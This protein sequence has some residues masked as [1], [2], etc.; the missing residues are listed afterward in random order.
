MATV[1]WKDKSDVGAPASGDRIPITDVDASNE[2]KYVEAGKIGAGQQT[3]WIPAAAMTPT[4][5]NGAAAATEELATND[6][7]LTYLAFDDST[8]ENACF[9]IQMP[10]SWD[11]STLISQFVWKTDATSG[12]CIWGLQ[13]VALADDDALDAAFGTAVEVT[14]AAA[15]AAD[16]CIISAESGALTVAGSPGAEEYVVFKVYRD[17]TDTMNGDAELLG[18]KIH[19]TTN[20][21]RDD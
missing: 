6:V 19:Y 15:S 8:R 4:T 18:V 12:N 17:A 14:D 20:A 11:A 13:A 5:T 9:A 1:R 21:N 16:D 2:D 3:I 10:K 7:M